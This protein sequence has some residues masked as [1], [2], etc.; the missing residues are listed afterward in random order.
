MSG[1]LAARTLEATGG[2]TV[3]RLRD[4]LDKERA[5][6]NLA[7]LQ[8][9]ELLDRLRAAGASPRHAGADSR[10][11]ACGDLFLALPGTRADGRSHVAAALQAGVAAVLWEAEGAPADLVTGD[12]PGLA[13]RGLADLAGPLASLIEGEP[14]RHL[15]MCGITGT[16]GKTSVSQWIADALGQTGRRCAV[17]GTLGMAMAGEAGS[18]INTTPEPCR[19]QR[20]LAELRSRGAQAVSMEASSIG[21]DQ[22]RTLGV[23]FDCAV[24]TNLTRD[25]LD[26]HGDMVRYA[27]A[28]SRLFAAPTLS[29]VVI[30]L[31]DP[32]GPMLV[33]ALAGSGVRVTGY[34]LDPGAVPAPAGVTV[35]HAA[36]NRTAGEMQ[37]FDLG[38]GLE[39]HVVHTGIPGRFNRA[40]LLAVAGALRAAGLPL[41]RIAAHLA[42]LQPVRGRMERV[43]GDGQPL[44]LVDYAHTPDALARVLEEARMIATARGGRLGVVF[45]CGGDR[46]AGKRE[47]MGAL[48]ASLADRVFITSDNPRSESPE[49]IIEAIARGARRVTGADI[50]GSSGAHCERIVDRGQAIGHAL[51]E[52][53][54]DDVIVLAGKGHEAWQE[55]MGRREPFSDVEQAR[56]ALAARVAC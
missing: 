29:D 26:Y 17:V 21:L 41:A 25:H 27:L 5:R 31:D 3:A 23:A 54:A 19:L 38:D 39:S 52:A 43:G 24:F 10:S 55:I 9:A 32:L 33:E 11:L 53:A 45:G 30:N 7:A 15:W 16:N 2:L 35:L 28:K 44:V 22:G 50:A 14:S 48:A 8:A 42:R 49:A 36:N 13:V 47:Q 34:S 1:A 20:G 12:V 51:G 4:T 46:D 56:K 37:S 6:S 18:A 40:N